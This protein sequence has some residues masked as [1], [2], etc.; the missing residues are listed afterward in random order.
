L[1]EPRT[2]YGGR[3]QKIIH[4]F[5]KMKLKSLGALCVL[6]LRNHARTYLELEFDFTDRYGNA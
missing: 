1:T 2:I 5:E 3:R 6:T 4:G